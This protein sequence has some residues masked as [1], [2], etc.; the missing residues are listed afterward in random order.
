[1]ASKT[2]I[3]PKRRINECGDKG[4]VE[5]KVGKET[6][7][8][9]KL[10]DVGINYIRK[11]SVLQH[12]DTVS[13]KRMLLSENSKDIE[14][15]DELTVRNELKNYFTNDLLIALNSIGVRPEEVDNKVF[16]KCLSKYL[17]AEVI[18]CWPTAT[19][20]KKQLP[21]FQAS[22]RDILR[23]YLLNKKIAVIA[24]ELDDAEQRLNIKFMEL[25]AFSDCEP[26][27][28]DTVLLEVFDQSSV[29]LAI[30][31]CINSYKIE[32]ENVLV[33]VTNNVSY[34]KK[35]YNDV[36]KNLLTNCHHVIC[37]EQLVDVVGEY[38]RIHLSN[39]EAFISSI[40]VM[41]SKA[42]TRR[43]RFYSYLKG[44]GVEY[45]NLA[46]SSDNNNKWNNWLKIALCHVE[47]FDSYKNFIKQERVE[48][49]ETDSMFDLDLINEESDGLKEEVIFF[50][51]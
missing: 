46:F 48:K 1:M 43:R 44:N 23:N 22:Q 27:L 21:T 36:L 32:Y 14:F 29:S 40:N 45:S 3:T 2:N 12:L 13:H 51:T 50:L 37:F 33:F 10:C 31:K 26:I 38:L 7:L 20:L 17:K 42:P 35:C 6:V 34:M 30:I 24:S 9:C 15:P 39:L 49:N 18:D 28:A 41:C 19:S 16:R 11:S 25:N 47:N 8:W 4:L 5:R